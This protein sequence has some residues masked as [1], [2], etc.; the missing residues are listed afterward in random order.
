M[1]RCSD[2]PPGLSI[3][4]RRLCSATPCPAST[5][6]TTATSSTPYVTHMNRDGCTDA[7]QVGGA[8]DNGA[9]VKATDPY[10]RRCVI[11]CKHCRAGLAG[12]AVGT[13]DLQIL[14]STGRPVRKGDVIVLVTDGR[15]SETRPGLRQGAAPAPRGPGSTRHLGRRTVVAVGPAARGPASETTELPDVTPGKECGRLLQSADEGGGQGTEA[16]A[17][18]RG[19]RCRSGIPRRD[20]IAS[21][22]QWHRRSCIHG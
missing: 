12:A 9:D 20:P 15:F 7:V 17:C 21:D 22:C 10:G 6:C 11:Q 13:P 5:S 8:G 16:S 1:A 4:L 3:S 14:N 19:R 18:A 2:P